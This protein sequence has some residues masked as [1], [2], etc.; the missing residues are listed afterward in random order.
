MI[1]ETTV[2][3]ANTGIKK[4]GPKNK[5][6]AITACG[7]KRQAMQEKI[8]TKNATQVKTG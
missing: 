3:T 1:E 2:R 7:M 6:T 5:K 4:T 8:P